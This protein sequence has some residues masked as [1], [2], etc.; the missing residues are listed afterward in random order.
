MKSP[1]LDGGSTKLDTWPA[2][3]FIPGLIARVDAIVDLTTWWISLKYVDFSILM[4]RPRSWSRWIWL[5]DTE[6]AESRDWF[7]KIR[8]VSAS[9][10]RLFCPRLSLARYQWGR[11]LLFSRQGRHLSRWAQLPRLLIYSARD[12]QGLRVH[13]SHRI[14]RTL[15]SQNI[16]RTK[17]RTCVNGDPTSMLTLSLQ[18]EWRKVLCCI[19]LWVK[20]VRSS[21]S[22][23]GHRLQP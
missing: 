7:D 1:L 19:L 22:A 12:L 9:C 23:G 3:A 6:F 10:T 18:A 11:K 14:W 4:W 16:I 20:L 17:V 2:G 13:S 21:P 5:C 15:W 8:L